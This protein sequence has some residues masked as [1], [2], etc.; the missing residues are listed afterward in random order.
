MKSYQMRILNQSPDTS[1]YGYSTGGH[2]PRLS[3]NRPN[4]SVSDQRVS[5]MSLMNKARFDQAQIDK[6]NCSQGD[7]RTLRSVHGG[8]NSKDKS[9]LTNSDRYHTAQDHSRNSSPKGHDSHGLRRLA[10]EASNR[11]NWETD[12]HRKS[13]ERVREKIYQK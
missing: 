5:R 1:Q 11:F 4:D 12:S 6:I 9:F 10:D 13:V 3:I 8:T 2:A 7:S